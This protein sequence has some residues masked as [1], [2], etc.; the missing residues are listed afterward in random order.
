MLT[1]EYLVE[2]L[3]SNRD[4]AKARVKEF[5]IGGQRFEFNSRPAI[6]GVINLSPDS[7][8]VKVFA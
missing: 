2:L 5:S 4:A 3:E 6:M 7:C 1:L 8:I